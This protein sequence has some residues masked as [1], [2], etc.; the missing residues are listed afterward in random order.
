MTDSHETRTAPDAS[1]EAERPRSIIGD[2]VDLIEDGRTFLNAEL[3]F[4]KTRIAYVGGRG[5]AA[6]IAALAATVFLVF[7]LFAMVV[8]FIIALAPLITAWGATA[9]VAG[10]LFILAALCAMSA[11]RNVRRARNAFTED[12][13]AT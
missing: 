7:G 11:R 1:D 13:D 3:S 6:A 5:Q 8:G 2:L 4:Q 10:V 9:V 12:S